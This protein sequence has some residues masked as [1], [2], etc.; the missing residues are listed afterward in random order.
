MYIDNSSQRTLSQPD[1]TAADVPLSRWVN[2]RLPA[3]NEI[4]TSHEVARL[5]RRH[6]WLLNALTLVGRFPKKHQFRGRPV[7]WL[8]ADVEEWLGRC[9]PAQRPLAPCRR[10]RLDLASP[11]LSRNRHEYRRNFR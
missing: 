3:W 5:T 6:H 10:R 2:E 8:R 11:H 1:L 9:G 7:G 4:L